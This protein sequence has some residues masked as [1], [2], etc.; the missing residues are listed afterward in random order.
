MA[1]TDYMIIDEDNWRDHVAPDGLV[2]PEDHPNSG[3]EKRLMGC[4]P[5]TSQPG[6]LGYA[7][8][9]S[10][11][12]IPRNEWS[13]RIKDLDAS[14]STLQDLADRFGV[15]TKDQDGTNYCHANS[16]ALAVELIRLAQGE[17]Y[18]S[19]SPGSIGGPITGYRNQGASIE[20]DLHQ[21]VKA[22][23]APT[24]FVPDNQ[25][26]RAGWKSGAVE[27]ALKYRVT[28]WWDMMSKS[29]GQMFDRC[30]TLVL[31]NI[32][33]CVGY[34]WWSHAVTLIKLIEISS[35][36]F[37]FLFRNS[38]GPSYGQNGYAVLAEGRGTP[39]DA[40]APRQAVAT[41]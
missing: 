5:R 3:G 4:L 32:P 35:G 40:Y 7:A 33:V 34:N 9:P 36:K 30:A 27:E 22:G 41:I 31:Q 24:L 2:L 14:K 17:S 10:F 15:P 20:D 29:D 12:L 16:P 6:T 1:F 38:W 39:D 21:I 26:S 18:V 19:L 13:S 11:E 23:I 37:G 25:I 8:A 28:H